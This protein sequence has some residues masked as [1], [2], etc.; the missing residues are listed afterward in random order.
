M[1]RDLTLALVVALAAVTVAEL[2]L[3]IWEYF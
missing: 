3:R 2:L 1:M